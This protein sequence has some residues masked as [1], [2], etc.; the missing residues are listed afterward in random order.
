MFTN[1]GILSQW[2]HVI[3]YFSLDMA[4]LILLFW[5]SDFF[6]L[7]LLLHDNTHFFNFFFLFLRLFILQ[8]QIIGLNVL[9]F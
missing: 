8:E 3:M 2:S 6:F 7:W 5:M 1:Y 4:Y 9:L